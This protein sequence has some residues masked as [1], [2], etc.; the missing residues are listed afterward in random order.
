MYVFCF[1]VFLLFLWIGPIEGVSS[2]LC[3]RTSSSAR[4]ILPSFSAAFSCEAYCKLALSF[5][6]LTPYVALK[7]TEL[8]RS[9]FR[10]LLLIINYHRAMINL[11]YNLSTRVPYLSQHM[12]PK[13][14][15]LVGII[16]FSIVFQMGQYAMKFCEIAYLF[17]I[18]VNHITYKLLSFIILSSAILTSNPFEF[19]LVTLTDM[20]VR[21]SVAF[22][23]TIILFG[24]W[25]FFVHLTVFSSTATATR[26]E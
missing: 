13:N 21:C 26:K 8:A 17:F 16:T 19:S 14:F 10:L 23:R 9:F 22:V 5:Q 12:Y 6:V 2:S 25:I 11:E 18:W 3:N 7:L 24:N 15:S 4:S 1:Y 20:W